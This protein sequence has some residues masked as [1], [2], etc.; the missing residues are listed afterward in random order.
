[1]Y[2]PQIGRWHVVDPMA[3]RRIEWSTYAYCL[4]NPILRFDP[5]GLTDFTFDKKTGVATEVVY[6]DKDEQKANQ[7]AKTDRIVRTDK[8]GNIKRKKDGTVKTTF[9][10][11][12][13]KGILSN[14]MNLKDNDQVIAVGGSGQPTVEGVEDFA[15]KLSGYVGKEIGGA[16]FSQGGAANTT[17]MTIGKYKNNS[18]KETRGHGN[19]EG[20]R[21]GLK[22]TEL[23]AFFHTHP[24]L[25]ISES[26]RTRASDADKNAR[27]NALKLMPSMRFFIITDPLYYGAENEKIDYT[28][29]K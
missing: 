13:E 28:T 29:H 24:S 8:N 20:V 7:A 14:G 4:N 1:M 5:N 9:V 27:D 25:G 11:N 6:S 10:N 12:I 22:T 18:L 3:E 16:Y 15:L 21:N 19:T 26:D 17:H 23:T 2:D